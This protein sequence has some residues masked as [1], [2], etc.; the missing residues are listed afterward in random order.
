MEMWHEQSLFNTSGR[1]LQK[2][3]SCVTCQSMDLAQSARR[4][5]EVKT[6]TNSLRNRPPLLQ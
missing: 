5:G 6:F 2:G 3:A 1:G 4:V